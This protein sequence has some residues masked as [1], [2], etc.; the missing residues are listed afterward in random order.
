MDFHGFFNFY[1]VL[2]HLVNIPSDIMSLYF[3]EDKA[4][5]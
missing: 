2:Y 3:I 5:S 4:I 1:Q